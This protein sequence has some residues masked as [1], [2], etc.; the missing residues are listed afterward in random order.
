MEI[1]RRS[2]DDGRLA[3]A[4][5]IVGPRQVGK[6]TLAI[7][8]AM[9]V[10]CAEDERPCGGCTQCSRIA[11][12]L[13]AGV[14]V[15]G[16]E[17]AESGNARSRV[18]IGIDQVREVQREAS[19]APFEG[20]HRIIIF[21][22]AEQLSEEAANS[23]LKTLEEPPDNVVMLLL[24]SS[25]TSLPATIVSRCQPLEL[26]PVSRLTI[27]RELADRYEMDADSADEIARLSEG[28]LGWA[29]RAVEDREVLVGLS[30]QLE[31]IED[32][33]SG[34]LERRFGYAT[35]LATTFDE[36]RDSGRRAL[37][38]WL[39]WWR[40][41]LVLKEGLPEYVTH[42]SRLDSLEAAAESLTS[43]E[44]VNTIELVN[45]TLA[46]LERNVNS[47]LAMEHLMLALP[48]PQGLESRGEAA[49]RP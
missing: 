47:R 49:A 39:A 25:A 42:V 11:R 43:A 31:A 27:A 19:L 15:V 22:G 38:L 20:S 24:T 26:R 12:G 23:L 16:V 13:H 29:I 36:D 1:L 10:S 2:L 5:L 14:R 32:A 9:A 8:L 28:R 40:D 30:Q 48:R 46:Y 41:V 45:E 44:V 7:D 3:H 21:D 17:A 37:G 6:M 33:V 4:Y 35:G 18:L 34:G